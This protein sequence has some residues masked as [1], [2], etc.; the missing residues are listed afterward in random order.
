MPRFVTQIFVV[1]T[2]LL[3]WAIVCFYLF[4]L[5]YH[6]LSTAVNKSVAILDCLSPWH[7]CH[8]D[9]QWNTIAAWASIHP[10]FPVTHNQWKCERLN[11][12][13]YLEQLGIRVAELGKCVAQ[14]VI[15]DIELHGGCAL[16]HH[17]TC[18]SQMNSN[19]ILGIRKNTSIA[20]S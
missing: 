9:V 20:R 12:E 14:T 13:K 15:S 1:G 3:L 10:V 11:S 4:V 2:N 8:L 16:I 6:W 18:P 17:V 5:V 19:W 7:D